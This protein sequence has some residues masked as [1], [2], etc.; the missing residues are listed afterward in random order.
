MAKPA[1]FHLRLLGPV[2]IEQR[3]YRAEED[4][5]DD[6][7]R[8]RSRRTIALLGYLAAE[9]RPVARTLLATLFW[10][11]E[12]SS[13]GRANL[14]RELYNLSRILPGCWKLDPQVATFR[15]A[16]EVN[17][18]IYAL[19]ALEGEQRWTEAAELLTGEFMEGLHLDDNPQFE[20]WL[21]GERERWRGRS[22]TILTSVITEHTRRAR[23][24]D[25]LVYVQKLLKRAPW[26]EKAHRE[27][28]RLLA[29]SGKRAAALRQ[30]EICQEALWD[31][32]SAEPDQETIV[33]HEQIQAGV[34]KAPPSRPAYLVAAGSRHR[35]SRAPF[36]A[37]EQELQWLNDHL[38]AVLAGES[39]LV[40]VT[41]SPGRGKTALLEAFAQQAM[42]RHAGLL[43]ATGHCNAYAGLG[44]PYLP[45]REVISMLTADVESLWDA[46]VITQNH[47]SRLWLALPF[48]LRALLDY[49]SHLLDVLVSGR[50]LLSRAML[51]EEVAGVDVAQLKEHVHQRQTRSPAVQQSFLFQEMTGVLNV[52]AH[53]QPLLLILDDIQWADAA[54]IGLLFHLGRR[55]PL[56]TSGIMIVCAYRAEDVAF[57]RD[58]KRHP[59]APV[60]SE[61]KRAL[62]DVWLGL[63]PV[64]SEEGRRFVN[65]LLDSEPNRLSTAFRSAMLRR[66]Q[67]H[68]LFTVELLRAM[69]ERGD[70]RR[71]EEGRWVEGPALNWDLLPARA[72]A[73]IAERINRLDPAWQ[74]ILAVASVEGEVF[75]AQMI[76]K[77]Q[78][79]GARSLL[80]LLSTELE[81]R[82]RLIREHGEVKIA[83]HRLSRFRFAHVLFQEYLYKRLSPGVRRHLHAEVATA[84]ETLHE[85]ERDEWAVQLGHHFHEA[86]DYENA[87]RYFAM[88]AKRAAG[89]HANDEAVAYFDRAVALAREV[90]PHVL[91]LVELYRGRG[92][93]LVTLGA[94][95]RARTDFEAALVLARNEGERK[96]EWRL[97]LDLG[98]AWASRDYLRARREFERALSLAR[99]IDD[100]ATLGSSLNW[101]GNWHANAEEP[102]AA[103]EYHREALAIFEALDDRPGLAKTLDL[104]GITNLLAANLD[105]SIAYYDRAVALLRELDAR[106]RLLSGLIG[107]GTTV[108][109]LVLLATVPPESPPDAQSDIEEA[110][111]I[112]KFIHAPSE[113]AW[114]QWTLGLLYMLYGQFASA[115]EVMHRGIDI[116]SK[117]G[118]GEWLVGNQF[119]LGILYAELFAGSEA[120]QQL[121]RAL[122]GARALRS[123]Y[124]IHHVSGALATAHLI[125]DEPQTAR[126]YLQKVLEPATAM[127]TM[128][129][130]YCWTRQADLALHVGDAAVALDIVDRL[131]ETAPGMSPGAVITYLWKL[132][133]DALLE[134]GHKDEAEAL[135]QTALGNALE[136]GE[137]FLLWRVHASLG[138][139][140]KATN[141][142][143]N[144]N[145]AFAV[146]RDLVV[147]LAE[148]ITDQALKEN[149]LQQTRHQLNVPPP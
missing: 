3:Q 141:S 9:Q 7:P 87:L 128:G 32:L 63:G 102:G 119:A 18:D 148:P 28:M 20:T 149:Y 41:G 77:V 112:A 37:R 85:G 68:P 39:R 26:N 147:E 138:R 111:A 14:R 30:F 50:A 17:V 23:Y 114:A 137:R 142:H 129:K 6:R 35:V 70:L 2:R 125:L 73:V 127:D 12:P 48:V 66:T 126:T 31:E 97:L 38:Q 134:L 47:A 29:W 72:E 121:E 109:L 5:A 115:L 60:L 33:L 34:I 123:Q 67:G 107:R 81:G 11:D 1:V 74:E 124:W 64:R 25:A 53:E 65:A 40:F 139:L 146:A 93:V 61:F 84:L 131:I 82:H 120:R 104:L 136:H 132:K 22:E 96:V 45:F 43:V 130:R 8:F 56:A 90:Q 19:L 62:G 21:L 46:G 94:L 91:Q 86:G 99:K 100:R 49:G 13:R 95:E 75:T 140:H 89:M 59:L 27:A 110:I 108:S 98:K 106:P 51:A 4:D 24:A 80:Q 71:D 42:A 10:P 58:G 15:P 145:L 118:H 92:L 69:Q 36:V 116:A 133:G 101:I 105:T 16:A 113:E 144:A 78:D 55:L 103:A 52:I 54:S 122:E 83:R 88:A 44:D 79:I 76:A 117:I 57:G 143:Q 135:L